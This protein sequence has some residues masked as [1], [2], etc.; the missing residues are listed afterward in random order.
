MNMENFN[1]KK[2]NSTHI[3]QS[4]PLIV[5]RLGKEEYGIKIE[6]VKEVT[7]TPSITKMPKTPSFIRGVAN[8]R[9]DIIAIMDLQE[10]FGILTK[11][12]DN[13]S[14]NTYTLV[15]ER[16]NYSIGLIV[17]EVP[18]TLT[19]R[20]SQIEKTP[21]ILAD[22]DISEKYIEGIGKADGR[23][24]IMLDIYKILTF[25]EERQLLEKQA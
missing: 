5:F 9:G 3:E 6:Q 15:V 21:G 18:Q 23:L 8:I 4:I 10:R 14:R 24:I 2:E 22:S 25:E 17:K 20:T 12:E 19:L 13:T 11:E 16:E 1:V 7:I